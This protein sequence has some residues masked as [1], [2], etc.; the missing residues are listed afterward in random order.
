VTTVTSPVAPDQHRLTPNDWL[1]L[2]APGLVWGTSFYFI[3]VALDAFSPALITPLRILLG[4]LTLSFFP[5]ARAKLPRE[6]LPKV[7]ILGFVWMAFP[8]TMF[9]FAEQRVSSSVTGMLNGA[10]P[11]FVAIVAAVIHRA[12]PSRGLQVGLMVGFGG[13]VL[14]SVPTFGEGSSS[15][16]GVAM[17][18]AALVFYGFAL[19][20]AVPL[21]RQY[22]ALPVMWRAQAF[23]LL[24]TSPLAVVGIGDSHFAWHSMVAM[25]GLGSLGTALAYVLVA[26]N[27]GRI[28]STRASVT[29]Y[30]IPVVSLF[31]GVVVLDEPVAR[32]AVLGCAVALLGA[33]LAG[34]ARRTP[35]Q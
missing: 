27:A 31:L 6:V 34:R 13:V 17:I 9:P 4:F 15:G 22:G 26:D 18:M 21:Q 32:I 3:A 28:G 19:N 8:L 10:T 33:W 7:A 16:W 14:I 30:L 1:R 12:M 29:T 5:A 11:L 24:F 35:L 2:V 20:M 25:I 23:A